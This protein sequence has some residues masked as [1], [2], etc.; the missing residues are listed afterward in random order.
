[1]ASPVVSQT[2]QRLEVWGAGGRKCFIAI[3]KH[4]DLVRSIDLRGGLLMVSGFRASLD[5]GSKQSAVEEF[6]AARFGKSKDHLE[7]I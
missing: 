7:L 2:F 4:K 6:K 5:F 3:V 1:M